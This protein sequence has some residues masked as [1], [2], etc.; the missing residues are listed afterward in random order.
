MG[1]VLGESAKICRSLTGSDFSDQY[2]FMSLYSDLSP[3]K[4]QTYDF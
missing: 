3:V 2:L 4:V 1:A